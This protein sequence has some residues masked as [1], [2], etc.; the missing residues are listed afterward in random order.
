MTCV[1]YVGEAHGVALHWTCLNI[2]WPI[3]MGNGI[4]SAG[5]FK[6]LVQII[7]VNRLD[8]SCLN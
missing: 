6:L 2:Y 5:H 7:L 4:K 3:V 8:L 1:L